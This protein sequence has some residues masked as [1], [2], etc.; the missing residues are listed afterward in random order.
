MVTGGKVTAVAPGATAIRA[1]GTGG[2]VS[3]P[4]AIT[5][6]PI[7]YTAPVAVAGNAQSVAAGG[8]VT[9]NGQSS[10]DTNSPA[11]PLTYSWTL[12]TK[13]LSSTAA[14]S[15]ASGAIA[16]F[17]ADIPG[18]YQ[19]MLTVS[20]GKLSSTANV[21]ITAGGTIPVVKVM[22][23]ASSSFVLKAD[24]SLW[25]WGYNSYGQLGNATQVNMAEPTKVG[26]SGYIWAAPGMYG[27]TAG[28]ADG[29][30]WSWGRN[31]GGSFGDGSSIGTDVIVSSPI[32]TQTGS[33]YSSTSS[34]NF[35]TVA[36]KSDGSVFAWGENTHGEIGDGTTSNKY[37]PKQ[38]AS[39]FKTVAAGAFHTL[40]LKTD[41]TL[42]A[43]GSNSVGQLGTGSTTSSYAPQYVGSN[44]KFI[45]AAWN[46]T[47]A[48]KTDGS[49][50][51]WGSGP[52]GDGSIQNSSVPKLIGT[53]FTMVA[54]GWGHAIALK[55]DGSIWSWGYNDQ[56]Q[57]G[58][59]LI[60][61]ESLVP[62]RITLP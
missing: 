30:I 12:L 42:W 13:P 50:W 37:L 24:G 26:G 18:S 40:G 9:L 44:F 11:L 23:Y 62:K 61:I 56:G 39:G 32:R 16:S 51:G 20:N 6:N 46:R 3:A 28:K 58:D 45:S 49:L 22:A 2:V 21:V 17:T 29:S 15:N 19:A 41:G 1:T 31:A 25:A 55:T 5:V 36:V 14:L 52:L 27:V 43:W 4:V 8:L 47:F 54:P 59:G 35:Y 48:I 7:V 57:L 53:G 38:V 60:R 33:L 10:Y 34:G